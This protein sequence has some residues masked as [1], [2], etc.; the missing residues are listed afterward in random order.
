MAQL[1]DIELLVRAADAG[2]HPL[3]HRWVQERARH[4]ALREELA[5]WLDVAARDIDYARSYAAH[6]PRS[7][8]TP[9]QFLDRWLPVSDDL[10]ALSGPRYRGRDP[11]M[12]FV[13]I[14]GT[15]RPV[16]TADLPALADFARQNYAV[17]RPGYLSLW[18]SDAAGEWPGTSSDQRL[19]AARL[20]G[21]RRRVVPPEL[22]ARPLSDLTFYPRYVDLYERHDTA[23]PAHRMHARPESEG[24]IEG[25]IETGTVWEVQIGGQWAGVLAGRSDVASGL[26]GATVVELA[27]DL[28][29]CGRGYGPH[30]SPLLAQNLP[31]ADD[32]FL[33]GT[34]HAD[35]TPAYR[36]ATRAGRADVGGE[37]IIR[38]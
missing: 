28:S 25:L 12:P 32:Q 38:L 1:P 23:H 14:V 19:L 5:W 18:T 22:T 13:G 11:N 36:S 31:H 16:V 37:V 29:F 2:L 27:L 10:W 30:L 34:I 20:D 26:R 17:F 33:F 7:G 21:L 15:D 24:D 9:E 8:A 4:E 3:I 35:N 6:Q